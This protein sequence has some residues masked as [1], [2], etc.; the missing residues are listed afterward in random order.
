MEKNKLKL[1]GSYYTKNKIA[2]EYKK[3]DITHSTIECLEEKCPD[4][5]KKWCILLIN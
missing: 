3:Y 4:P 5:E 2:V 1:H